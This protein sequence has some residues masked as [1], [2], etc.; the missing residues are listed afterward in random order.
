MSVEI[1]RYQFH[2][3]SRKG[4]A[5]NITETDDLGAGTST[6]KERA[7]V[8]I[9]VSLNEAGMSK[10]F[11]LIGPG[12][13]IG[14][15]RDMIVRTEPLNWITDFEANYLAFVE[16]YDEDFAWR[17]TPA[18]PQGAKL[19][20]WV[21]LLVLKEEEFEKTRR[22]V[23]LP[24]IIVKS[25]DAFP[26]VTETSLWAH[27]H[28][29]ADIPNSELSD[30]EK[31]LQSLNKTL[32]TDPDKLY[33]RVMSPRKLEP[34]TPYHAFIIPSFETGRL[35]GLEQSTENVNAQTASWDNTNGAKGEMPFYYEW[36]F[37]TGL[38]ADFESLVKMLEP[39]P[40]DKKVGIRDMDCS[41]PGFVRADDPDLELP[42]TSPAII[43]LE[44]ALK[45]PSTIS[46]I[47][48][49]PPAANDFQ[50]ELQKIVNLPATII[51]TDVSGDPIISLP[52]Y[53]GK[54]AKKSKDDVVLLDITSN[55]WVNDLNK[56]P[57]TRVPAGFGTLVI[58]KNQESYMRKA[59]AQVQKVI[60]A[61]R[62]IRHTQLY[63]KVALQFTL[64]TFTKVNPGQFLAMSRP[65]LGRI[66][67]S[68]TTILHQIKESNLPATVFSGA[69]RRM[70]RPNGKLIKRLTTQKEFSYYQFINDINEGKISAAPPRQT[71]SGMPNTQEIADRIFPS[72]LPK[73]ILWLL[74]NSRIIL[75]I[76]LVLF[77]LLAL[78]TG[79]FLL[80]GG[81]ALVAIGAYIYVQKA[82]TNFQTSEALLDPQK[83]LELIKNIPQR[84]AFTL[85]LSDEI[86]TPAPTRGSGLGKDSLEAKNYREALT[87]LTQRLA[88]KAPVKKRLPLNMDN[89]Y[90]KTAKAIHPHVA[91]PFRLSHLVLFPGTVDLTI[92]ETIFPAIAYP[93]FEDPMYKKLRDISSELLLPNLKL[94][95]PNTIS[96]LETNQKFIESYMVGL[97]HEM[98]RELLWREYPT[99]ERGCYFRQFWDVKGVI[100]PAENK[101][102]AELTEEYKDIKPIHTW[103]FKSELGRHNN[104]DAQGDAKQLVLVIRGDLL[105]RYPNTVIF[106]QKAITGKKADEPEIDQDL[107]AQEFKTQVIFPLYKAEI[108]PD[109]KFFGFDLTIEQARGTEASP[110]FTDSLGWFF[111]IQEVPGEPRF[112]M[113][114]SYDPGSDG[115]SWDDLSWTKF[116]DNLKFIKGSEAPNF[117]PPEAFR[118]GMDSANMAF[119]LFQKPSMVAVHAKEMLEN[120]K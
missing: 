85:K 8:S 67:G 45:S 98:G 24:T 81:I 112:G 27:V 4:I 55:Y 84:P 114:L 30:Y 106:A 58:Q 109:I 107:S 87:H 89:A 39:R 33:C 110:G 20:P 120:V 7:E 62:I 31:F 56:D 69:F 79:S 86:T 10:N 104:R 5:T 108:D 66:I 76:L 72:I 119:I 113:D 90:A 70:I 29:D 101:S 37:R 32:D 92:P 34:N 35:A 111:I 93:D 63:M 102:E 21:F 99:D 50:Q 22:T 80:F 71:P 77:L 115:V 25:K 28:S 51:G 74:K 78:V 19:R 3:W 13:I 18:K 57:R 48:P 36:Y 54:H 17:Y 40:M 42:G 75:I 82:K 59:W 23:P 46:T 91:Y 49:N 64:Q 12:D 61:N 15:N 117:N 88:L 103:S 6:N 38:N 1:A 41:R 9:P 73:W 52:L 16:F 116:P 83:E 105:K 2:S 43:G 53:G 94:I 60:D 11:M 118:W 65:V 96:L 68:P 26:P 47:F 14:I 97:N 44:G 100:R 95:P